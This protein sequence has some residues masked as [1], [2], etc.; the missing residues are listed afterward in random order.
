MTAEL[1]TSRVQWGR[2]RID[3]AIRRSPRRK[4]VAVAVDPDGVLL[5]APQGVPVARL[6]PITE[7]ERPGARFVAA[8]GALAGS[9]LVG[10]DFE[11]TEAELDE[12][13]DADP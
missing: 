12:L 4:T 13:L 7:G 8:R 6:V 10:D 5:T 1:E 3:Y 11:F 2:T 9:I